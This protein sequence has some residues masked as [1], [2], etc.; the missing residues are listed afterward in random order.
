MA[1]QLVGEFKQQISELTLLPA[2]GGRFEIKINDE[3]VYSKLASGSF[4]DNEQIAQEVRGR[5]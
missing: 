4:P 1:D 5:L 3:L 2:D